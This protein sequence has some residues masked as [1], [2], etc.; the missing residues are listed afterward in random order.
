MKECTVPNFPFKPN[1]T[2]YVKI[3][4]VRSDTV[5]YEGRVK[6]MSWTGRLV[7]LKD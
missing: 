2:L 3:N 1:D 5:F 6:K 7:K 4:A